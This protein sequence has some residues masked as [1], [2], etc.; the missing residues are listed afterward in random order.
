M[1]LTRTQIEAK[2]KRRVAK[3][4]SRR[5]ALWSNFGGQQG[6][7]SIPPVKTTGEKHRA[8]RRAREASK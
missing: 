3:R 1:S 5:R 8:R 7:V 4:H 6:D 2:R